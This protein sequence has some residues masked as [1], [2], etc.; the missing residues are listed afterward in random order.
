MMRA[1]VSLAVK[2]TCSHTRDC[3]QNGYCVYFLLITSTLADNLSQS[4]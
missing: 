2:V 1:F 3:V 4:M